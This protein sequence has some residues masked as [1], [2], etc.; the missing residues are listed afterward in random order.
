MDQ[1]DSGTTTPRV[2]LREVAETLAAYLAVPVVL[3]YPFGF[4]ALFLQFTSYFD[5][6]F[7]TA[8]YAV[9]L[10]NRTIVI[11]QGATILLVALLGSVLL[12]GIVSQILRWRGARPAGRWIRPV[13]LML[14]SAAVLVL[15]VLYS[16]ILA[17]GKMSW[18]AV[19]GREPGECRADAL[20]HQLNLWPDSLIPAL[21]F[22]SGILLGGFLIYRSHERYSRS[23]SAEER[24]YPIGSNVLTEAFWFFVRGIMQ[25][26]IWAGLIVAYSFGIAASL[27]LASLTPG[28]MP[29]V[30]FGF[31]SADPPEPP[32]YATEPER[33]PTADR[34][35]SYADAQWHFLHRRVNREGERE[36]RVVSLP[37]SG[38]SYA[39]V[40]PMIV[41]PRVAPLPWSEHAVTKVAEPCPIDRV[42]PVVNEPPAAPAAKARQD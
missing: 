18:L 38:T 34:L 35:L 30:S 17:A 9:S 32:S 33:H 25:R 1:D 22:L 42:T 16:R 2:N 36:Y 31:P 37:S 23:S 26:W 41:D 19:V 12:S 29:Y 13:L 28:F 14:V 8:W 7:Y 27:V 39:R 21:I 4:V 20:R 6:E 3:V 15:Y 11:G 10:V 5:L 40:V 24:R